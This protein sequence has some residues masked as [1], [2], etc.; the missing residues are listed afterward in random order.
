MPIPLKYAVACTHDD[1]VE[2]W[3][4]AD[5]C[6]R[7]YGGHG[8]NGAFR[9]GADRLDRCH[10]V[11]GT[12]RHNRSYRVWWNR[13]YGADWTDRDGGS[14][15]NTDHECGDGTYRIDGYLRGLFH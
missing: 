15:G 8:V 11:H 9:D 12:N 4:G 14:R 5:R 2:S 6:H 13:K 7:K 10:G 3:D 1:S